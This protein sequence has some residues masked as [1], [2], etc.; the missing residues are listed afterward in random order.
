MVW[1]FVVGEESLRIRQERSEWVVVFWWFE[2]TYLG[3]DQ[4]AAVRRSLK[5]LGPTVSPR[6][7]DV[8]RSSASSNLDVAEAL[9]RDIDGDCDQSEMEMTSAGMNTVFRDNRDGAGASQ[10]Q[11]FWFPLMV[12][13]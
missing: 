12:L 1:L 4:V 11:V 5:E 2:V 6:V 13:I 9:L 10:L 7:L 8:V 3:C